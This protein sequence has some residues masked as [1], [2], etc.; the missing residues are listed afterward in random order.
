MSEK[1]LLQAEKI[2][3]KLFTSIGK[4]IREQ[5]RMTNLELKK[6]SFLLSDSEKRRQWLNSPTNY[7]DYAKIE[8]IMTET[9]KLYLNAGNT[10]AANIFKERMQKQFTS[11]KT[12]L[13]ALKLETKLKLNQFKQLATQD[14][15]TAMNEIK[16]SAH[17]TEM[18]DQA[19]KAGGFMSNFGK[20]FLQDV[21]T[22]NTK[23]AGSKTLGTYMNNL[24]KHHEKEVTNAF[25]GGLIRGD[26]YKQI[27][28]S[29]AVASGT[30]IRKADLLV[31]TEANAIFNDG[32]RN[33]IDTNPMIKGYR[34]RA[35]LDSRTSDICQEMDGKYIAKEDVQPGVNYPPLHPRCRSTVTVVLETEDEKKDTVQRYTKNGNNEWVEVPKGTT[36][37]QFAEM[38]LSATPTPQPAVSTQPYI[39]TEPPPFTPMKTKLSNGLEIAVPVKDPVYRGY[40]NT[41]AKKAAIRL[42][43]F[44]HDYFFGNSA[45]DDVAMQELFS[46]QGEHFQSVHPLIISQTMTE[47]GFD[48]PPTV[49]T[50]Q[51]IESK[52]PNAKKFSLMYDESY[53]IEPLFLPVADSFKYDSPFYVQDLYGVQIKEGA[54]DMNI[55][56]NVEESK[57]AVFE[58]TTEGQYEKEGKVVLQDKAN[59]LA[60]QAVEEGYDVVTI[61]KQ[62][63]DTLTS[64]LNK[65]AIVVEKPEI[66]TSI[67]KEMEEAAKLHQGKK[68]NLISNTDQVAASNTYLYELP[69]DKAK[70]I[71]QQKDLEKS[72]FDSTTFEVAY[73]R[74]E[75]EKTRGKLISH[76]ESQLPKLSSTSLETI[77]AYTGNAYASI[78]NLLRD[79]HIAGDTTVAKKQIAILDEVFGTIRPVEEAVFVR[80]NISHRAL[81]ELFGLTIRTDA[82]FDTAAQT[83]SSAQLEGSVIIDNAFLSTAVKA[84]DQLLG[85][86]SRIK[87][88]LKIN[89][90]TKALYVASQSQYSSEQEL[91]VERGIPIRLLSVEPKKRGDNWYLSVKAETL[92]KEKEKYGR[93]QI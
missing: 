49:L 67:V 75:V 68:I 14:I 32:V 92:P 48:N 69:Q 5:R 86:G 22:L 51:E 56:L 65:S 52:F 4:S 83:I 6:I 89:E 85:F 3:K 93:K 19:K 29:L 62:N 55:Y 33:V 42:S 40:V 39:P 18:F 58:E 50:K 53:G 54:G 31:T 15:L 20:S 23:A 82:D 25:I 13:D 60:Y 17:L 26:S 16:T 41:G 84:K 35:V 81:E 63:G 45:L 79:L 27:S 34:F 59:M 11:M 64:V 70:R 91:L 1:N 73:E 72:Y 61:K 46:K 8:A 87:F 47:M 78:N 57:I 10:E 30:T 9:E 28:E 74:E 90:G 37:K 88:D 80:R 7:Q 24:F 21:V 12:N 2:A 76:F 36:Y 43:N 71:K 66:V 77:R 38:F 44:M